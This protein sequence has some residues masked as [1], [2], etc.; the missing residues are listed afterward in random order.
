MVV[1]DDEVDSALLGIFYLVD[2]LYA[3]VEDYYKATLLVRRACRYSVAICR[4]RRRS[5]WGYRSRVRVEILQISVYERYRCS[6]VNVVVAVD[7]YFSFDPMARFN[8]S[9]AISICGIRKGS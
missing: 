9:T 3:A 1:A 5:G 6:A 7:H 8:R 4:S 2:S